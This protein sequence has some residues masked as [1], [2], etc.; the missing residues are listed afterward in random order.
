ME[1]AVVKRDSA[2]LETFFVSENMFTPCDRL[3]RRRTNLDDRFIFVHFVRI[4]KALGEDFRFLLPRV[5]G[6]STIF[7]GDFVS[8]CLYRSSPLTKGEWR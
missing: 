6:K 4:V 5:F 8:A 7:L 2:L 1:K 3:L